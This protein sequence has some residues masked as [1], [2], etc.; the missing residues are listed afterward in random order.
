[1]VEQAVNGG[2]RAEQRRTITG[3]EKR[4]Q[5]QTHPAQQ[6]GEVIAPR[7]G[8]RDIADRVLE[9]QVPTD[10]PRDQLAERGVGIRVRAS[11]LRNHGANSA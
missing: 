5:L 1:M 9:D 2:I 7:N 8:D 6:R 4:R 11:G 3:R 10:D